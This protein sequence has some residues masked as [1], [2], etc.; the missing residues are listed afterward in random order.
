[1]A[2]NEPT[3]SVKEDPS[4]DGHKV[5]ATERGYAPLPL[6]STDRCRPVIQQ[7]RMS[8]ARHADSCQC[9]RF[10]AARCVYKPR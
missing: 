3:E 4:D 10:R 6:E 9:H 5:G 2:T 7:C 8:S 1:M